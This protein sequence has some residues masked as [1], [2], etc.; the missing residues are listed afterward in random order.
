VFR[1]RAEAAGRRFVGVAVERGAPALAKLGAL[2]DGGAL[3]VH[4]EHA[5]ALE[6]APK[7]HELVEAGHAKGK[8]VLVP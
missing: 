5:L 7:A 4:V 1:A 8:I 3:R 2:V 6:E